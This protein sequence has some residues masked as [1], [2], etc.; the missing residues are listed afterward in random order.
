MKRL[1]EQ[2]GNILVSIARRAISQYL[3][4]A[5]R[6]PAPEVSQRLREKRGVFVTLN[7][8]EGGRKTLR[9]CIGYPLP[10]MPLIEA[11]IGAAIG[12]AVEDPRFPSVDP[13]EL[14]RIQVEVSVLT[15]PETI[16]EGERRKLPRLVRVGIDGLIIER[17]FNKGLLLPQVPVEWGWNAEEFLG[18]TCI[19]AG[20]PTT[21]W[22]EK[23]VRIQRFQ[24]Q[25]FEETEPGGQIEE[26]PSGAEGC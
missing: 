4:T 22:L 12:A 11:T 15:P 23:D 20:L 14:D 1:T 10:T 19:K 17:G 25:I 24:A 8:M 9:G 16:S 21:S 2:E 26:R 18:Q 6:I 7:R 13:S 3:N 5:R